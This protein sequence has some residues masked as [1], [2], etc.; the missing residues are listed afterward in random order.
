MQALIGGMIIGLAASL[1]LLMNG[2]VP[3]ISG[4]L[5]KLLQSE[6]KDKDW[7][8]FFIGGLLL[9]GLCLRII[10]PAALEVHLTRGTGDYIVAGFLVGFGTLLG[11]GCT[12]GHGVCGL[13]RFSKRSLVATL[14]FMSAG[15]ISV[16]L[17]K[18]WEGSL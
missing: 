6:T 12:S 1:L 14:V 11:S 9:G 5:G 8:I 13:S 7:R 15:I 18:I 3:G 10:F 16:L 17:S 4:I 2:R